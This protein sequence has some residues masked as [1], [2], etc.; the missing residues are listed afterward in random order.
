MLLKKP[1]LTEKALRI[2][3]S[4][5]KIVFEVER[6]A[7]KPEI[8]KEFEQTFNAKVVKVNTLI[9]QKGK[10]IAYIKLSPEVKAMD[11]AAKLG[12]V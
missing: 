5:N 8:K 7:T 6:N 4:E 11:I 12:V 3:E 1:V 2:M 10:K 9:N